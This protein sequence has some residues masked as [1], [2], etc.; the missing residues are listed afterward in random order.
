LVGADQGVYIDTTSYEEFTTGQLVPAGTYTVRVGSSTV[1]HPVGDY[2]LTVA[3]VLPKHDAFAWGTLA[4]TSPGTAA[5]GLVND[6]ATPGAG[7]LETGLSSDAYS[8]S[9]AGAATVVPQVT[10]PDLAY[11]GWGETLYKILDEDGLVLRSRS[12]RDSQTV[13]LELDAGDYVLKVTGE[14]KRDGSAIPYA[15]RVDVQ[16]PAQRGTWDSADRL[17]ALEAISRAVAILAAEDKPP[18]LGDPLE[19]WRHG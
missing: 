4:P 1:A 6:V 10:C 2:D 9:L 16:P 14:A 15:A 12:C 13:P 19:G 7:R 3:S 17:S 18:R 11:G 5:A 8:F